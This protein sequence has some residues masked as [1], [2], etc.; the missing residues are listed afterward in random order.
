MD[1]PNKHNRGYM[2]VDNKLWNVSHEYDNRR[3]SVLAERQLVGKTMHFKLSAIGCT[4]LEAV[5]RIRYI[6]TH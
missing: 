6:E 2:E 1:I 5:H 3:S 4:D